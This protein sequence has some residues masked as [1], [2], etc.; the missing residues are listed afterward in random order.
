MRWISEIYPPTIHDSPET[1]SFIHICRLRLYQYGR[2]RDSGSTAETQGS[3]KACRTPLSQPI[4]P[5]ARCFRTFIGAFRGPFI[6]NATERA[7]H[8]TTA[9]SHH[10]HRI[11]G[12]QSHAIQ[13]GWHAPC[14]FVQNGEH[15]T[16]FRQS[17]TAM[18]GSSHHMD[19][20]ESVPELSENI[21]QSLKKGEP[22]IVMGA[23]ATETWADQNGKP[24]SRIVLEASAAGHDLNWGSPRCVSSS[25]R[26]TST[27]RKRKERN[28]VW[29]PIRSSGRAVW[30]RSKSWFPK[31]TK[32][33]NSREI[34]G[35]S[36]ATYI[37]RHRCLACLAPI[38]SR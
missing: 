38:A 33:S 18:E 1:A 13:Q 28:R 30:R 11:C 24:Q 27:S 17:H 5:T 4:S 6:T 3:G 9:S 19:H 8:G 21:C 25:S 12:R 14:Q 10:H 34:P 26:T 16:V 35:N 36:T 7:D 23:L 2:I 22:V 32:P 20:G 31:M 29:E 37:R 15:Q